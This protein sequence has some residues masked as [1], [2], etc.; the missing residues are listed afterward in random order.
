ML[1]SSQKIFFQVDVKCTKCFTLARA[2]TA[3]TLDKQQ[4]TKF[5]TK[6]FEVN[7]SLSF[8]RVSTVYMNNSFTTSMGLLA[9]KTKEMRHPCPHF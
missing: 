1:N 8:L 2:V 4:Q 5:E 7:L 3:K 9:S 6:V